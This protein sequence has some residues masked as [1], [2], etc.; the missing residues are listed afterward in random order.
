MPGT[1]IAGRVLILAPSAQDGPVTAGLRSA[2]ISAVVAR[3]MG[4]LCILLGEGAAAAL[5]A[6]EVFA[7]EGGLPL[8]GWLANQE[9]WSDL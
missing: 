5:V 8:S 9:P 1:A 6:E 2:G 7:C 3:D 4:E